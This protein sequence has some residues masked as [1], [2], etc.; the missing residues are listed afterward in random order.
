MLFVFFMCSLSLCRVLPPPPPPPSSLYHSCFYCLQLLPLCASSRLAPPH[1]SPFSLLP[2]SQCSVSCGGGV[3]TRSI[4][5]LRQ[6]RPA[7]GCLPHQRP[8][9]SRA[10]NTQFCPAAAPAPAHRS[11]SRVTAA[12]PTLKGIFPR[13][14]RPASLNDGHII[15]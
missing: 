12:G 2:L 5:C 1:P 9:T 6:G 13:G 11:V 15:S 8:V 7:A 10:C 4:Q 14:I 3:Q